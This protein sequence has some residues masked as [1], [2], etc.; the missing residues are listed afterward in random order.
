MT[1]DQ[2]RTSGT[3]VLQLSAIV[4]A[5][6]GSV[7]LLSGTALW[8][9]ERNQPT[10]TVHS[11]GDALWWA[12][13]TLTTTGYGDHVPV[14][15]AGRVIG[16]V[17]MMTGVAVIGAVAAVIAF[18]LAA[19]LARQEELAVTAEAESVE[20]RLEVRLARIEAQLD[21]LEAHLRAGP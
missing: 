6:A 17:V 12:M 2:Q 13:T 18:G 8:L 7:V 3:A 14:T 11:Y 1:G 21:R 15:T 4:T 19:R 5:F 9:V 20:Q 16:A 10:S